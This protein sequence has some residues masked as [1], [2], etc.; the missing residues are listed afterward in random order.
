MP[1]DLPFHPGDVFRRVIE[2]LESLGLRY[3]VGGSVA[4]SVRG[5]ERSTHDMDVLLELPEARVPA[6]LAAFSKEFYISEPAVREAI[7]QHRS[8][9]VI[10]LLLG[11]KADLFVAGGFGLD[12]AQFAHATREEIDATSGATA[13]VCSAEDIVLVKL[14][15]YRRGNMVS[16]RQWEDVK[17]VLKADR[18]IRLEYLRTTAQTVGLHDLL[19]K[20][21]QE[22]G[23]A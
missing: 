20:A 22:S 15:W 8:F 9:N 4:S 5:V 13:L 19:E 2:I 16:D 17:N 14:D 23:L 7:A 21:L 6:L 12:E 1:A 18:S 11:V 10:H 3:A